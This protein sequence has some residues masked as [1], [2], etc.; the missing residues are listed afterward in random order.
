MNL[1]KFLFAESHEWANVMDEGG[2]IAGTVGVG[3]DGVFGTADDSD[4]DLVTDEF[5]FCTES[6]EQFCS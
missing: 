5:L 6:F 4:G 3:P 1:E 2:D